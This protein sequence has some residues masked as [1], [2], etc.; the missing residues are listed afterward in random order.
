MRCIDL[1]AVPLGAQTPPYYL[2]ESI[3]IE[4][5]FSECRSQ[6]C[7]QSVS[8]LHA[9]VSAL[10]CLATFVEWDNALHNE[11]RCVYKTN[12]IITN[13]SMGAGK[14]VPFAGWSMPIQYTDSIIE[15]SGWCRTRASIFDVSHM[16]GITLKV[17]SPVLSMYICIDTVLQTFLCCA[18]PKLL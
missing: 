10:H 17:I 6:R 3:C 5:Q 9:S 7:L 12:I 11:N 18:N 4:E 15:S 1:C 2:Q 16:C 13:V 14:M 8:R